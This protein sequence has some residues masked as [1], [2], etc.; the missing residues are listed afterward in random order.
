MGV[1]KRSLE[2]LITDSLSP[3]APLGIVSCMTARMC[4]LGNII[5][6]QADPV[7]DL[8]WPL[9]SV[10]ALAQCAALSLAM[11]GYASL[12]AVPEVNKL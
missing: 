12:L 7:T 6:C 9:N 3:A 10:R 8:V 4:D 2:S 11:A 1:R 5:C